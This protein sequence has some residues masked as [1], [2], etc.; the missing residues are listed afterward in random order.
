MKIRSRRDEREDFSYTSI[1]RLGIRKVMWVC[2]APYFLC[3]TVDKLTKYDD[4]AYIFAFNKLIVL[5]LIECYLILSKRT[6]FI[7]YQHF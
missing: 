7:V 1:Y 4:V 2:T 6:E 3:T 5:I